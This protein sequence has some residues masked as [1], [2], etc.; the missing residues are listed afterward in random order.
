MKKLIILSFICTL[1]SSFIKFESVVYICKGP[2]S[3]VYH[4]S[5]NCKGLSRCSTQISK[6]SIEEAKKMSRRSCKIEYR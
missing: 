3:T 4:K 5:N 2:S 6:I 1:F